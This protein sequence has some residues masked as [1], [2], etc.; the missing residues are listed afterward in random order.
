MSSQ[1][2]ISQ[3]IT[4]LVVIDPAATSCGVSEEHDGH[5]LNLKVSLLNVFIVS[6]FPDSPGFLLKAFGNDGLRKGN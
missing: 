5:H 3:F 2:A 6:R 1:E 4:L